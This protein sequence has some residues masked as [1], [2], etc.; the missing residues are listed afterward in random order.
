MFVLV[1]PHGRSAGVWTTDVHASFVCSPRSCAEPPPFQDV[2][3]NELVYFESIHL[4][5]ELLDQF[6]G[7]VCELDLVFNFNKVRVALKAAF[8]FLAASPCGRLY[9]FG[10]LAGRAGGGAVCHWSSGRG[11]SGPVAAWR[12]AWQSVAQPQHRTKPS[13]PP[14]ALASTEARTLTAPG[15]PLPLCRCT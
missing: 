9:L 12:C 1:H 14:V 11:R 13:D 3:D 7:N 4:F 15:P 6:F 8:S 10:R 5:V 2:N